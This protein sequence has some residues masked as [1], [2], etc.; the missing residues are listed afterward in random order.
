MYASLYA[1]GTQREAQQRTGE[2]WDV[3]CHATVMLVPAKSIGHAHSLFQ[4]PSEPMVLVSY[5]LVKEYRTVK[6]NNIYL[7]LL[8][9]SA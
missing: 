4:H 2:R 3:H 8:Y 9:L 1:S 5:N 7:D 6:T